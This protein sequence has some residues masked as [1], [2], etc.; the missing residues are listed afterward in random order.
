MNK[1]IILTAAILG[2]LAVSLGAFG[3]HALKARVPAE[4]LGL[5]KTG[6]EYH[7][8]HTLALLFLGL[9]PAGNR[10]YVRISSYC[11][12]SGIVLFSGSLY[13]LALRDVLG[14]GYGSI[15]GPITPIGGLLFILGWFYLI[16]A[17]LKNK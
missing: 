15:L 16:L 8:Y 5:W 12:L 4:A 2:I 14:S 3:A 10:R 9:V 6:V 13:L 7:F 11:M 17:A 1:R